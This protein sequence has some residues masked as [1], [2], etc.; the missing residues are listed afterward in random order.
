MCVLR[1]PT[2]CHTFSVVGEVAI[3]WLV[4]LNVSLWVS[5]TWSMKGQ[6]KIELLLLAHFFFSVSL[7][8]CTL[9]FPNLNFIS[10]SLHWTTIGKPP[11]HQAVIYLFIYFRKAKVTWL[12]KAAILGFPNYPIHWS[13]TADIKQG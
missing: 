4:G 11:L 5:V 7:S 10:F 3:L 9:S 2:N 8:W 1:G 13:V 12:S 6:K